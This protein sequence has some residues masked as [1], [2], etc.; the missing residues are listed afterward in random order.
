MRKTLAEIEKIIV[1]HIEECDPLTAE[2]CR[3]FFTLS[4]LDIAEMSITVGWTEWFVL[5]RSEGVR[6]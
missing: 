1:Y 2:E 4:G 5:I 3:E 6:V